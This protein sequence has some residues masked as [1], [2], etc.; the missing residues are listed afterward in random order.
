MVDNHTGAVKVMASGLPFDFNQFDLAVQGRRNPGSSFKPMG[1]VAALEN[2]FTMGHHF[3][4]ESPVRIQCPFPCA[5]D[6]GNVWTV[7]NA[8]ASQGVISLDAATSGSVNA[9]Y[10]QLSLA[11]GPEKIV[12]MSRRVD[13]GDG[14]GLLEFRHQRAACR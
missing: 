14:L 3:S 1:L 10:A 5:P 4:G 12:E 6:G 7:H 11:V 9:V 8:G 13:P 2:G